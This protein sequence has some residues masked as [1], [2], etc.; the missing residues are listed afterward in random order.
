MVVYIFDYKDISIEDVIEK[1]LKYSLLTTSKFWDLIVWI[2][3]LSLQL[4]AIISIIIAVMTIIYFS[5]KRFNEELAESMKDSLLQLLK[6][7]FYESE[8]YEALR[9]LAIS[10]SGAIATILNTLS[11]IITLFFNGFSVVISCPFNFVKNYLDKINYKIQEMNEKQTRKFKK[12]NLEK[13]DN[14][15]DNKES[16]EQFEFCKKE[17]QKRTF[18]CKKITDHDHEEK[19]ANETKESKS[20]SMLK[21]IEIPDDLDLFT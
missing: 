5:V 17:K 2:S 6:E 8:I 12:K 9:N 15:Q 18:F 4:A 13:E 16:Y 14:C 3:W 1:I 21:D 20:H 10:I 11:L 19:I 7:N